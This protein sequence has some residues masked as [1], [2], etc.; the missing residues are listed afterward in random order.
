M[1]K[2]LAGILAT[3]M[4]LSFAG[5][6]G[7][8]RLGGSGGKKSLEIG[9]F[10]GGY[11]VEWVE[12]VAEAYETANDGVNIK[13]KT[14]VDQATDLGKIEAGLCSYDVFLTTSASVNNYGLKGYF[15]DLSEVYSAKSAGEQL[16]VAQKLGEQTANSFKVHNG[17]YY[18]LP[19]ADGVT[20]LAYNKTVMDGIFAGESYT[21]PKTTN[22]LKAL[23]DRIKAKGQYSFVYTFDNEAEYTWWMTLTFLSQM[24]GYEAYTNMLK[25]QYYDAQTNA[26]VQ[27]LTGET[28][29]NIP[30]RTKAIQTTE[31]LMSESSGYVAEATS[32]FEDFA[33]AQAYFL[34]LG[35]GSDKSKA[36]FMVNGDWLYNETEYL[37]S[38]TNPQDLRM[39]KFPIISAITDTF[40]GADRQMSD[41][42][43]SS[44]IQAVDEGATNSDLCSA[45]TFAKIKE[46]RNMVY[47]LQTQQIA[48]V[49]A[50]CKNFELAK[51]FLLFMTS[52]A[53]AQIYCN[54]LEGST[55]PYNKSVTSTS[56]N[57][58]IKS[59]NAM[60]QSADTIYLPSY[61]SIDKFVYKEYPSFSFYSQKLFEGGALTYYN[62]ASYK[63]N[64]LSGF[65]NALIVAGLIQA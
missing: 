38:A 60:I 43:L 21:L 36:C 14:T 22:E 32:K 29:Y 44:I 64:Y 33:E 58:Y 31:A 6:G 23:A 9:V 26:F 3:T 12:K 47:S 25:G 48:T 53:V 10:D 2:T 7:G 42:T 63:T 59:R 51:D 41:A 55:T 1:K 39:M 20:G 57:E 62:S 45:T 50:N 40:E 16:T 15:L 34:G 56:A 18:S 8:S 54:E 35:Y 65:K 17:K 30:E 52:D 24:M 11:G 28:V 19:F 37:Q 27:D 13:I 49:P 61:Y 5:C 46:A 4:V